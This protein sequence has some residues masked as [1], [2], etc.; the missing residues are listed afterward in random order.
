VIYPTIS[1]NNAVIAFGQ[2]LSPGPVKYGS[3]EL[4]IASFSEP[5]GV[6][7]IGTPTYYTPTEAGGNAHYYEPHTF[8]STTTSPTSGGVYFM[9]NEQASP[10]TDTAMNIYGFNLGTQ[11][12]TNLT[13]TVYSWYE[14]PTEMPA[15]GALIY[16]KVPIANDYANGILGCRADFWSMNNDG[17]NKQ[18]ITFFNTPG[19][20]NY[21]PTGVCTADPRYDPTGKLIIMFSNNLAVTGSPPSGPDWILSM[22]PASN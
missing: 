16:M 22:P 1:Q 13:G 19:S 21:V 9:G 4:A 10:A 17:T 12:L 2:R 5:A 6:P 20:P 3:W 8:A 18:Q 15:G 11:V 7:T 14:F